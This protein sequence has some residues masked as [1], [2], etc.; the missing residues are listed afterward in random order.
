[1]ADEAGKELELDNSGKKKKMMIIIIALVVILAGGGGAAFF[2]MGGDESVSQA[3]MEGALDSEDATSTESGESQGSAQLG[4]A[5]YVPMPR[6]FRFN[7]PGTVRD[8]FVEIRVQLL[9]RGSEHEESTKK[10]VPLLESTLLG[11]FSQ[12]S[13]DDLGTSAGKTS[14]KQK[15]LIEVQETMQDIANNKTIEQVLFTGFVMQ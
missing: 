6:P 15:A 7:V 13:A 12:A 11:V 10:H 2:F 14:L 1:M 3:E 8:R 9:V 5:V 4:T